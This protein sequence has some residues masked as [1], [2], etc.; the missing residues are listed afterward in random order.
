MQRPAARIA[1]GLGEWFCNA[2]KLEDKSLIYTTTREAKNRI[3]S[4]GYNNIPNLSFHLKQYN[5]SV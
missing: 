1:E 3:I 5:R 4:Q 2:M